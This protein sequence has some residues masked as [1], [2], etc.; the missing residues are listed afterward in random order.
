MSQVQAALKRANAVRSEQAV[1]RREMRAL[2]RRDGFL[3]LAAQLETPP[4]ILARQRVEEALRAV[5]GV[6]PHA[7]RRLLDAALVPHG[8]LTRRVGPLRAYRERTLTE[9]QRRFLA[10]ELRRRAR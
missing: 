6:G 3:A 1:W 7:A 10:S 2:P 5:P 9:S 4:P 8:A